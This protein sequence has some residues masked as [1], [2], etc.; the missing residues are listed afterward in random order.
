MHK[1]VSRKTLLLFALPLVVTALILLRILH[2]PPAPQNI[3][4]RRALRW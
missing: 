1:R 2:D 4:T 3:Q